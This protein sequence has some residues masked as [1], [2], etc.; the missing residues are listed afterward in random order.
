MLNE[1]LLSQEGFYIYLLVFLTLIGGACFL[2]FPEDL[3]LITV[4]ILVER[5]LA[6]GEI[7]LPLAYAAIILGDII[8]YGI[9]Y[10]FGISLFSKRWFR[11]KIP[12]K[13]I[14]QVR[15][16]LDD[17]YI[18][19]IFLGRHLFY[20][21]SIT[22]VCCGAV[23]MNFWRYII[24]DAIAALISMFIMVSIGF[25]AS[26]NYDSVMAKI[27][28]SEHWVALVFLVIGGLFYY[29]KIHKKI[30]ED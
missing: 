25:Y 22:F 1:W 8:L 30:T 3:I 23:K 24:A 17:N 12:P 6:H 7:I 2:P 16:H 9:G 5:E 29:F 26:E 21:R 19:T 18:M 14:K 4:G 11:N 15:E 27:D 20:L 10:R 28:G 13:K